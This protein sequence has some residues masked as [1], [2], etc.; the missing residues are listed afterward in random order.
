M[1][2]QILEQELTPIERQIAASP[3]GVS[4]SELEAALASVG[5][6]FN[7]RTLLRRL[8]VLIE[9]NRII[10]T[11]VLKGRLYLPPGAKPADILSNQE[12]VIPLSAAGNEIRRCNHERDR[13]GQTGICIMQSSVLEFLP[14]RTGIE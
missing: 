9:H 6:I 14:S 4:I 11:G 2:R 12:S 1:A 10:A 8:T 13:D 3:Q 5:V 7:R